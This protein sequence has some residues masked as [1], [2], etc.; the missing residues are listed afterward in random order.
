MLSEE[1][2]KKMIRLS[3]YENG[4]GSID[5]RRTNYRK[6]DFVRLQALKT[7]LSV[8]VAAFFSACLFALYHVNEIL[9]QT[10]PL[11][12]RT[13]VMVG[14]GIWLFFLIA[15]LIVSCVHASKLYEESKVRVREYYTTLHEL[16][17][18]YEKEE[19]GQEED[20]A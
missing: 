15:G 10:L 11:S 8:T 6:S 3:D 16:L 9:Y 17:E 14:A 1:K 19:Q 20:L 18:I 13:Y 4:L 7:V 2:I 12:W 5:L